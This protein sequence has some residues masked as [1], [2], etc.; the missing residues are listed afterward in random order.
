MR[1]DHGV[2]AVGLDQR[3]EDRCE[4]PPAVPEHGHGHQTVR[5]KA[6]VPLAVV[7]S[8]EPGDGALDTVLAQPP[9]QSAEAEL[10]VGEAT[11]LPDGLEVRVEPALAGDDGGDADGD[12]SGG[13]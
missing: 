11:G 6:L 12:P 7:A 5:R 3:P 13:R 4:A 2:H 10:V 1:A 9:S 8:G